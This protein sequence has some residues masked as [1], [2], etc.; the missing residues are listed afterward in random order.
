MSDCPECGGCGW[1]DR[2][3]HHTK[4]RGDCVLCPVYVQS[5]CEACHGAGTIESPPTTPT[6][7]AARVEQDMARGL[8][9]IETA[10]RPASSNGD[11]CAGHDCDDPCDCEYCEK[12][13]TVPKANMVDPEAG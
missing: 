1:F 4:C 11:D 8:S 12:G 13:L 7:P 9:M 5:Q 3:E 6:P 2:A 10:L